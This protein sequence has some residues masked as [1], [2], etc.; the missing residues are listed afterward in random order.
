MINTIRGLGAFQTLCS[1]I[2]DKEIFGSLGLLRAAHYAVSAALYEAL[3][4][5]ILFLTDRPD[6]ALLALDEIAFWHPKIDRF[7]FPAPEPHFYENAAWSM[8]VR[9]DRIQTL[10]QLTRIL[11][12]GTEKPPL[13]PLITAPIRSVMQRTL[14]RQEFIRASK[15]L[16][17]GQ[18]ISSTGLLRAWNNSGYEATEAVLEPGQYS[19]R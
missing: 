15:Q 1:R 5:P 8:S 11:L 6:Q 13:M 10:T 9:H 2:N 14:S 3:E 4:R 16:R 18:E 12:P 19:R 7:L 17:I